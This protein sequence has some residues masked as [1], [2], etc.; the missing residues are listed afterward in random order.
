QDQHLAGHQA[1]QA[2]HSSNNCA[3]G[4]TVIRPVN[5]GGGKSTETMVDDIIPAIKVRIPGASTHPVLIRQDGTKPNNK[6]SIME[7]IQGANAGDKCLGPEPA[8]S[9]GLYF[10]NLAFLHS[11]QR[12]KDDVGVTDA[13]N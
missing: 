10:V 12:L 8:N 7:A 9:P 5:V 6:D 11:I 4:A 3:S 1:A 2:K 13:H